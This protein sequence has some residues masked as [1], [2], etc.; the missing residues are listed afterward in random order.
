MRTSYKCPPL[1]CTQMALVPTSRYFLATFFLNL[2]NSIAPTLCQPPSSSGSLVDGLRETVMRE[3]VLI[4]EAALGGGSG[5][6]LGC[7]SINI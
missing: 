4:R 6:G 1:L 2:L 3:T 5:S 7:N